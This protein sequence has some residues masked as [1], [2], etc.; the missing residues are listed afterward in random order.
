M[1]DIELQFPEQMEQRFRSRLFLGCRRLGGQHHQVDVA[2]WR[3]LAAPGAAKRH[4][5]QGASFARTPGHMFVAEADDLVVQEG[6]RVGRGATVAGMGCESARNFGAAR[7]E[8]LAESG[9][10]IRTIEPCNPLGD[11][12]AVDDRAP[13]VDVEEAHDPR[14]AASRFSR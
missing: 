1:A 8:R 13:V 9:S 10:G 11:G 12:A 7:I 6:R 5:R 3:H 14:S 2:V 4:Q